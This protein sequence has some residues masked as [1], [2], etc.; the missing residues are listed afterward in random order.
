MDL[1]NSARLDMKSRQLGFDWR[2]H[3]SLSEKVAQ[4][5]TVDFAWI[6]RE[7]NEDADDAVNEVLVGLILLRG[8]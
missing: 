3:M 4:E 6:A 7:E 8:T 2:K 5:G 1:L